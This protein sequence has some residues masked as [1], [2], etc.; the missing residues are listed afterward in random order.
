LPGV[1]A[2]GTLLRGTTPP[3]PDQ[4]LATFEDRLLAGDVSQPT[5]ATIT[6]RLNDSKANRRR[7]DDG[8]A[9]LITGLLLGSPEFQKR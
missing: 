4:V 3:T 8:N 7:P 1:H 5:H 9:A 6:A 2:D